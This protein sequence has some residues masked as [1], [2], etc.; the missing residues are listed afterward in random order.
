MS[1]LSMTLL[2][3]FVGLN[4]IGDL[5]LCHMYEIEKV[6]CHNKGWVDNK[7]GVAEI[8]WR[9]EAALP[10][11]LKLSKTDIMCAKYDPNS[12]DDDTIV[13]DS[14][15][16]DYALEQPTTEFTVRVIAAVCILISVIVVFFSVIYVRHIKKKMLN[17]VVSIH[18]VSNLRTISTTLPTSSND[19]DSYTE[20]PPS[21]AN[22]VNTKREE[23][24]Y[25]TF[26]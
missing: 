22:A 11:D 14:C 1:Q 5:G 4:C 21:Y 12:S 13:R 17:T 3:I 24:T 26:R 15:S 20:S 8:D 16:C 2:S 6:T 23:H 10:K 18:P 9:C 7:S 19:N 25:T